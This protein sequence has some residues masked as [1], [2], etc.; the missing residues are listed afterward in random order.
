[1][2]SKTETATQ[3]A[4]SGTPWLL[5]VAIL[6]GIGKLLGVPYLAT[7]SW[8]LIT[9]PVWLP[10]LLSIGVVLLFLL[11]AGTALGVAWLFSR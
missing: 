5:L 10:F 11:I 4:S 7:A 3:V 1:M 9:A 8:W 6:L 2:S